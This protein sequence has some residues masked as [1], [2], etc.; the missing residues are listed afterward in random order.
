VP[1]RSERGI[2]PPWSQ[3]TTRVREICGQR[4]SAR[5]PSGTR[6]QKNEEASPNTRTC[7]TTHPSTKATALVGGNVGYG[8]VLPS[9][10]A[11]VV[12]DS[13]SDFAGS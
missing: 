2:P 6:T 8:S 9:V 1:V 5:S 7:Y 11:I 10:W 12:V 13:R 3:I 4:K